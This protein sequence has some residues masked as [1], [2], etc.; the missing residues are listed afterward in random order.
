MEG[1]GGDRGELTER[2]DDAEDVEY[3]VR[4]GVLRQRLHGRVFDQAAPQPAC[5]LDDHRACH[6]DDGR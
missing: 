2:K 6:D 4:Q 3:H 1:K 5:K